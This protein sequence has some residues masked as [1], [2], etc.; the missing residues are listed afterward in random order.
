MAHHNIEIEI[1]VTVEHIEPL[2]AFLEKNGQR[3]PEQHQMDE[4]FCP[5][6]RDFLK[7]RPVKEW[8][9]LRDADGQSSVNYKN[10]HF[11]A[12]GNSH[13]CDELEIQCDRLDHMRSI[14][15]ALD[16]RSIVVVDKLRQTWIYQDYE[17]AIDSVANLG[18]F[19]EIEYVGTD[20]TAD[21]EPITEAMVNF[22]KTVGCGEIVRDYGG[23]PFL[24]LFLEE[25]QNAI[26]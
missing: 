10:W 11:D 8:L 19:V 3:Q 21:P 7:D 25:K 12:K 17:V 23:Y 22:L 5:A 16:F 14:F 15:A 1:K 24:P 18:E 6:H 2:V 13:H 26:Q 4:Y 9:R 20:A